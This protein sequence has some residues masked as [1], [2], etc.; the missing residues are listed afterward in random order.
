M[1]IHNMMW[2]LVQIQTAGAPGTRG[3]VPQSRGLRVNCALGNS[4][5]AMENCTMFK[6]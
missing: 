1:Y 4:Q 2:L 5:F 3:P 6:R